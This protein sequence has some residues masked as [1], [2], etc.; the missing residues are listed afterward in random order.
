MPD[1]VHALLAFP[2]T[3]GMKAVIV[4]WKRYTARNAGVAWQRDF[5]DHRIREGDNWQ[6]KANYV[7][8]NPVRKGL[9]A[10]ADQW[11]WKFES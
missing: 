3:E 5:F 7:R 11:P 4:D 8:D 6:L 2:R 10:C 9:I 1:H